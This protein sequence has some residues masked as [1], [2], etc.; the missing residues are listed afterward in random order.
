MRSIERLNKQQGIE[1]LFV[2]A[3]QSLAATDGLAAL[4]AKPN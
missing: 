4:F 3:D 2:L 1:A